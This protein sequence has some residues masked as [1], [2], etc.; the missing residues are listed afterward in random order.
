MSGSDRPQRPLWRTFLLFLGPMMV[1]NIL[2]AMSGTLNGAFLGQMLG[3]RALAASAS[4]FPVLFFLVAFVLG[5]S[6]GTTV[7]IGQAWGAGRHDRVR[8]IAGTTY[9]AA[10]LFGLMVAVIGGLFAR[11]LMVALDTPPDILDDATGYARTMLLAMPLLFVFFLTTSMLRG[12]GDT[13]TPLRALLVSTVV[14]L[15]LTPAL[16]RGWLG[17]PPIGINSAAYASIASMSLAL[18]WLARHLIGKNHPLAPNG[19]LLRQLR[20]DPAILKNVVR[21]GLPTGVQMGVM[22]LAELVLLHF[23]NGYGSDAT[24]AYGAVN[25]VLSYVQFPAISISITASILGAQA[26]GAGRSQQLG[27]IARTG[28]LLNVVVTGALVAVA[29]LVSRP[30]LGVFLTSPAVIDLAQNLLHIV[31]WSTVAYGMSAVLSGTMRASGTVLAPTAISILVIL[32]VEVPTAWLLS[33]QI[34]VQGIWVAYPVAFCT[35]FALQATYYRLV[36]RRRGPI[37]QLTV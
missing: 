16:L 37:R 26:I 13:V 15:L 4:F 8:A 28:L 12:V 20:I 19:E 25:Q 2:Q 3:V 32:L 30:L 7:L 11:T 6:A 9:T 29:Y 27:Q 18:A 21:I 33:G 34:G 36:W 23:V 31:L 24:A 14:G 35:M 1:A 17:L 10:L 22:S 5:V